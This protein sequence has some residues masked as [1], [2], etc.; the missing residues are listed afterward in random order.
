LARVPVRLSAFELEKRGNGMSNSLSSHLQSEFQ[1][2]FRQ[3]VAA[4]FGVL[5]NFFRL[6]PETPEITEKMWGFAMAAYLDN[7]LPSVFKERLFVY[8]SRFCAV[9]YCIARHLGFLIGLGRPSGDARAPLHSNDDALRLLRRPLHRGLELEAQIVTANSW[10][11]LADM[12]A[13]ESPEEIAVFALASHVFVQTREAAR[14]REALLRLFGGVHFQYLMLFLTFV[15]AAHYW[16]KVHPEIEFEDDVKELLKTQEALASLVLSD[17]EAAADNVVQTLV[18]E[19][20][21]LRTDADQAAKLLSSIVE[22]SEDAIVSKNLDGIITTWNSGAQ[23]LFGYSREEAVGQSIYLLVPPERREEEASILARL[24]RG[25]RVEHLITERV[26]KDGTRVYVSLTVSPIRDGSGQV[27]GA[28]KIARD[29]TEVVLAERRL[30]ESEE[31]FRKLSESLEAQVQART[32]Q[33]RALSF[34]L[35]K[36]QDDERRRLARDMHDTAGQTLAVLGINFD[37]LMG[38]VSRVAPALAAKMEKTAELVQQLN[39][40]L[41]TT[42]YLL[43][44]PLLDEN[45]LTAALGWF[46]SGLQKRSGISIQLTI[47][48]DVGR[49]SGEAELAIFRLVQECLTNVHRHSGSKTASIE[50]RRMAQR[51]SVQV[52]DGGKGMSPEKLAEIQAAGS[53]VGI[54][55]MRERLRHLDG[56]L[57][58]ESNGHGTVVS[59]VIP[60]GGAQIANRADETSSLS[61]AV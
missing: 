45:G 44:P 38:D 15:H 8:L 7:P 36:A 2:R 59:A 18:D 26:R 49:L 12:P 6:A 28:S 20:A 56:E 58:I 32:E 61:A 48:E 47:A 57:T 25:E 33:L 50:I 29:M 43:H 35:L 5:P 16:T 46:V 22:S 39:R 40:E 9:R 23:R 60:V 21:L 55:G 52:R 11:P 54:R 10:P 1:S 37:E 41:R 31:R 4:R 53:G 19:L 3:H 30:R 34:H 13:M 14:C 27:I 17:P 24:R 42:S 51:I